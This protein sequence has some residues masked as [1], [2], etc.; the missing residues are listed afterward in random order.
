MTLA[1]LWLCCHMIMGS[2]DKY[3]RLC[4]A[5]VR[6]EQL[7][8]L[9]E[10]RIALSSCWSL[11]IFV[12]RTGK[13]VRRLTQ[14]SSGASSTWSWTLGT[15]CPRPCAWPVWPTWTTA[16]SS[17][18]GEMSAPA[19]APWYWPMTDVCDAGVAGWSP[20]YSGVWTWTTWP[21][22][23]TT[24]TPT[25]SPRPTLVTREG[26]VVHQEVIALSW[27]FSARSRDT[28]TAQLLSLDGHRARAAAMSRADL[29]LM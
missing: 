23:R 18:T 9:Y 29:A 26:S 17:W 10:V 3:C 19:R 13:Q 21:R 7:L 8:K 4:A 22:R 12:V 14:P 25:S 2:L 20:C 24:A 5:N 27:P 15:G 28:T 16:S 1:T 11:I 6:P